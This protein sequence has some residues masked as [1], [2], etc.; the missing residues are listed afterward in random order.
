LTNILKFHIISR[1]IE[2][3]ASA[4]ENSGFWEVEALCLCRP[5]H[6]L[7]GETMNH[8]VQVFEIARDAQ[9]GERP[10]AVDRFAVGA[11]TIDDARRAALERL[12]ADGRTVRSLSFLVDGGMAAVVNPP[13]AP[14]AAPAAVPLLGAPSLAAPIE[15]PAAARKTRSSKGRR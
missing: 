13:L 3:C 4:F 10:R 11:A 7:F 1:V 6:L 15:A 5:S 14:A 2:E 8:Q 9:P 12:V